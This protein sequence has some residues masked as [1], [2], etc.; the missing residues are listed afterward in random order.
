PVAMRLEQIEGTLGCTLI[1]DAYNS[2]I[3]SLAIAL[4]FLKRQASKRGK[5]AIVSDIHQSGR[6]GDDLYQS[7]ADLIAGSELDAFVG[8]GPDISAHRGK[9]TNPEEIKFYPDTETFLSEHPFNSF[10]D[11]TILVKGAR[12]FGFERIV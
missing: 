7:M 10:A 4:D 6:S 12:S 5:V 9:F 11:R 8:I 2:D 1:N 3:N